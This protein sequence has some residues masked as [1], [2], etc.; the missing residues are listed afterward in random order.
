MSRKMTYEKHVIISILRLTQMGPV[1]RELLRKDSRL[2]SVLLSK[3]LTKFA[4]NGLFQLKQ[5]LIEVSP[6]QRVNLAFRAIMLGGD[7]EKTCRFLKWTEFEG[8]AAEALLVSG[9]KV[10]RNFRFKRKGKRWE[11]DVIGFREP[12]VVCID[13]KHWRRRLSQAALIKAVEAQLQRTEAFADA[14]PNYW[15]KAGLGKWKNALI[16]PL[17]LSLVSGSPKFHN[18]VPIVSMLQLRDFINTLPLEAQ[19]LTHFSK[20]SLRGEQKLTDYCK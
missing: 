4:N 13:C 20:Q 15:M 6:N 17:I 18:N 8:V 10:L 19:L 12:L 7:L 14:L 2:D 1:S 16:V 5:N 9:F 3:L 11:I